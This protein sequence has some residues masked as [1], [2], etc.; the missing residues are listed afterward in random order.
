MFYRTLGSTGLLVSRI[1]AGAL[2]IGPLQLNLDVPQGAAVIAAALRQGINFVDT[3]QLYRSY[4]YIR[5]AMDITGTNPVICSKSYAHT[6]AGMQK[7]LEEAL[8][9]LQLASLG[10]FM[11]HEQESELTLKGHHE[12]LQFLV[13]AREKGWIKAT[14]ISTH[15]IKGVLAGIASPHVDVIHAIF[16]RRGLGIMDGSRE[17]MLA[18]L[19]YA[20]A[21]G[22]GV[23]AMKMY[24]GGNFY[25]EARASFDYV[26]RFPFIDAVAIGMGSVEEVELNLSWLHQREAP[27]LESSIQR[28][29]RLH[30][31][32]WCSGCGACM[33]NCRY[34]ALK[35]VDG[36]AA[37]DPAACVLCGYCAAF[38][39]DFCIKIV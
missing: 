36:S 30:I 18:A 17:Q 39:P 3:A 12:A 28:P 9:E 37:A 13:K 34:E 19:R 29:R 1:A 11:L 4:P 33:E 31:E 16:N 5:T 26:M 10:I 23:Y 7:S 35:L 22:K 15:S 38:C 6:A 8:D 14:G 2:T 25:R 21:C 20:H 24:G 32:S 27:E